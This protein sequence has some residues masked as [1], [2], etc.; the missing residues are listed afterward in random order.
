M[1]AYRRDQIQGSAEGA[2]RRTGSCAKLEVGRGKRDA[3]S[4]RAER[5]LPLDKSGADAWVRRYAGDGYPHNGKLCG[6]AR[7]S[8]D[9]VVML[10]I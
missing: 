2:G 1:G 6:R 5:R 9:R 3:R 10:P 8:I 4:G 7:Q